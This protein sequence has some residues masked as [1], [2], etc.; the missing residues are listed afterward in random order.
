MEQIL[1][2]K[3]NCHRASRVVNVENQEE[4]EWL[5]SWRGK[6]LSDNLMHC[7]YAHT[8]IRISD[9]E[10]VIINDKD[11][12]CWSVAEWKYEVNLEELWKCACDAFYATSFSPE[13]RGAYYI[14]MYEEELNDDI[15]KMPEEE[16]TRYI[17]KYKEWVRTLFD[18]HSRI[19]SAMITGPARFPTR[20]NEKM[21]NYY[22]NAVSEFRAW[23]E[24]VLKAIARRIEDAKPEEQKADEEWTR[25][26]RSI[27]SSASTIKG[28]NDGT[29]RGYNKA[30]FVS[31]IYGK[32]E[33]Y[34]K[35][36]DVTIVEKAIAYVRELNK[37]S[38]TITERHKFFKLAEM[39]KAVCEAQEV[40]SNKEDTEILFDGGRV[41]KNYSEDR[42][43]I[44]FDTKPQPD[45]ISN[46]KHNG[47]RWSPR[48]SAWQ[49]Q[50]TNNA[51]YAVTRVIPVT[52]E[53]LKGA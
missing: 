53:Q 15:K 30:L 28:I 13:E 34:A 5:F 52:I 50:L 18:K 24:K 45:V 48:F 17:S 33:T 9:N 22:E 20:R 29:E 35:R 40:R 38:S 26:K 7:D 21:N 1:L 41:I 44:V 6:K 39:A 19:M 37:Q 31:S 47:F 12:G 10:E 11:L 27:Y 23:R 32:V 8:A 42:V 2:S 25:L 46:L 16:R 14:R 3:K 43:Q 51:Y 4:G 49:R 36:G